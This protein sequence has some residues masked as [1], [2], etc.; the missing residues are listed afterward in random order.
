MLVDNFVETF[1]IECTSYF[2]NK[3]PGRS[4]VLTPGLTCRVD[5]MNP[6]KKKDRGRVG[7]LISYNKTKDVCRMRFSDS[8]R[9]GVVD[10]SDLLPERKS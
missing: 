9:I 5:P 10:S 2:G 7:T 6:L 3:R 8:N 1:K 4:V